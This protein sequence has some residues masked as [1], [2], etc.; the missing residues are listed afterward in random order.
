MKHTAAVILSILLFSMLLQ[1]GW[2]QETV[3]LRAVDGQGSPLSDVA[4]RLV[5]MPDSVTVEIRCKML[6]AYALGLCV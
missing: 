5:H 3:C 4:I 1:S 6:T 2:A